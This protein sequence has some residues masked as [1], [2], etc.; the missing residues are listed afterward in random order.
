MLSNAL[1]M[2]L[3]EIDDL[4][5]ICMRHNSST[6][7][8]ISSGNA[9]ILTKRYEAND[10]LQEHI[11]RMLEQHEGWERAVWRFE[12]KKWE[13]M[14]AAV[15]AKY[16]KHLALK[17]ISHEGHAILVLARREGQ[18]HIIEFY[19]PHVKAPVEE[20]PLR[21]MA[22]AMELYEALAPESVVK[23]KPVEPNKGGG[24]P[25]HSY[26]KRTMKKDDT[27]YA[28]LEGWHVSQND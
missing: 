21:T 11:G 4:R 14:K 18:E 27:I 17:G 6:D 15:A 23:V 7:L 13:R 20:L 16:K 28:S 24:Y 25:L 5:V 8:R 22:Q 2:F 19:I 3:H 10:F 1:A 26:L 12:I 9:V